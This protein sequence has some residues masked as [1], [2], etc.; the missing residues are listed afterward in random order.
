MDQVPNEGVSNRLKNPK[1]VFGFILFLAV[2][3]VGAAGYRIS[4]GIKGGFISGIVNDNSAGS[5]DLERT[6]AD[7]RS[8]QQDDEALKSKD[9]DGDGL[10]DYEEL[11]RY[12]TSPYLADT[13][14]DGT[15]DREEIAKESDPNC[16]E[17]RDCR[18]VA[19]VA[20]PNVEL[21]FEDQDISAIANDQLPMTNVGGAGGDGEMVEI[22]TEAEANEQ[23]KN[24]TPAQV[25]QLLL[26]S[27]Q[28]TQEQLD[29]ID[30]ETL[31][32]VYKEVVAQ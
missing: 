11:N 9:T 16:P 19:P 8:Q 10:S 1:L 21:G 12:R 14:S 31:M 26:D 30:D 2:V 27:G 15:N 24:L 25:R 20:D 5:A 28:V 3:G 22:T 4:S 7:V 17:G 13:D 23:L 32:R 29:A 6:T 18:E